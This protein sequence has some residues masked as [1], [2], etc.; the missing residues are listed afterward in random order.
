MDRD[1]TIFAVFGTTLSTTVVGNGQV[2]L[3]PP[4]GPYA[5]G[6][7]VRLTGVPQA[8]SYFGAWGNAATGNTNP[9]YFTI[10]APTQT[11]S[12]IFGT[13]ASNQ[14]A[15]TILI[16]GGG[17]VSASPRANVFTTNQSVV[18]TATPDNGQLFVDWTGDA[19]GTQNPLTLPMTQSRV[20]IANFS[21][22]GLFVY[23]DAGDGLSSNGFRFT[24]ISLPQAWQIYGSTNLNTWQLLETIT[25][26]QGH[27]QFSDPT[28]T[29]YPSRYYKAVSP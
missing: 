17:T 28:A 19:S 7:V 1:K 14:A 5:Y 6:T 23:P 15:L 25:N 3:Y 29:N 8:G 2:Q 20:V 24:L 12:S 26:S 13:L 9:L 21:A 22:P 16:N 10:L 11:V 4:T 18:L 27:F